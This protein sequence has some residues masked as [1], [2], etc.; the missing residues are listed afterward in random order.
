MS[1]DISYK[2]NTKSF[3]KKTD[4]EFN[5]IKITKNYELDKV[6]QIDELA[7]EYNRD[8]ENHYH[9]K[10]INGVRRAWF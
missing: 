6:K 4:M 7:Q 9:L 8:T 2:S 3:L 10:I 1:K 5:Q